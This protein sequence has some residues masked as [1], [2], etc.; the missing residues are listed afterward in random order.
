MKITTF[1]SHPW[2]G[3]LLRRGSVKGDEDGNEGKDVEED[4]DDKEESDE[5]AEGDNQNANTERTI[6]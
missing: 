6:I 1:L 3:A 2:N 4:N 5:E